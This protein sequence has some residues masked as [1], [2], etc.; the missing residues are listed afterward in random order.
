MQTKAMA[1]WLARSLL[2]RGMA[3]WAAGTYG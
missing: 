1:G 2:A 3:S